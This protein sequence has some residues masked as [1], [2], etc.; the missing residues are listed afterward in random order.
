[1]LRVPLYSKTVSRG[2]EIRS[3]VC[4]TASVPECWYVFYDSIP[5]CGVQKNASAKQKRKPPNRGLNLMSRSCSILIVVSC[6][7]VHFPG[8]QGVARYGFTLTAVCASHFT[9]VPT[10]A[11][12]IL[13]YT[14]LLERI[15]RGTVPDP[16][17]PHRLTRLESRVA[18]RAYGSRSVV[19]L[20][21]VRQYEE[22]TALRDSMMTH[23]ACKAAKQPKCARRMP[24]LA[25]LH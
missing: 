24:S 9:A 1:M 16:I 21:V 25:L 20:C 3:P 17:T 2:I 10:L 6:E 8:P 12:V 11:A 23:P 13:V 18:S 15:W 19:Q 5:W 4:D 14:R 22:G 7:L